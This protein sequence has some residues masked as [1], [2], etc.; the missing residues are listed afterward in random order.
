M[1]KIL[2]F[3]LFVFLSGSVLADSKIQPYDIYLPKSQGPYPLVI[4]AHG[5]AGLSPNAVRNWKEW[6]EWFNKK[7]YAVAIV[8]SWAD[9]NFGDVCARGGYSNAL[10]PIRVQDSYLA[11]TDI[12]NKFNIDKSKIFLMGGSHGGRLAYEVLTEYA[13]SQFPPDRYIQFAGA[14]G[15]YPGCSAHMSHRPTKAPLLF[16]VGEKDDWTLPQYCQNLVNGAKYS[17]EEG[18]DMILETVKDAG[19]AFD[20]YWTRTVMRNIV[21]QSGK[22]GVEIGGTR[23]QRKEAER[24]IEVF[25]EQVIDKKIQPRIP[26]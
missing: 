21:G 5:C 7:N 10:L 15:L 18:Y 24:M 26:H 13:V 2:S 12:S 6:A 4:L 3:I 16:I 22:V 17:K 8:D 1:K 23:S 11:A 9:R 14:I 20:Y 19:H 25:L